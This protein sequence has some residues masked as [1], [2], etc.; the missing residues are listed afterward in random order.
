MS[1]PTKDTSAHRRR[2][3][4]GDNVWTSQK[5]TPGELGGAISKVGQR[6]GGGMGGALVRVHR[7]RGKDQEVETLFLASVGRATSILIYVKSPRK[8]LGPGGAVP[9]K[10]RY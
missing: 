9:P 5:T 1:E 2:D 7:G 8:V 3:G 10:G 4:E 6:G